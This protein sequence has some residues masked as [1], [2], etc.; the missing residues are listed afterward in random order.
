MIT[1]TL[2]TA[3]T[4]NPHKPQSQKESP[5]CSNVL[6]FC[7][8]NKLCLPT[9]PPS[10]RR[11]RPITPSS[12]TWWR[13]TTRCTA[14][15]AAWWRAW[16]SWCS[17][18]SRCCWGPSACRCWTASS[19]C[20]RCRRATP[21]ECSPVADNGWTA[22]KKMSYLMKHLPSTYTHVMDSIH[23]WPVCS[24]YAG[25]SA[26]YSKMNN[27]KFEKKLILKLI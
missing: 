8:S 6:M 24:T 10:F 26:L 16:R 27:K 2:N 3:F 5:D 7:F 19:S 18:A 1:P 15:R 17:P 20:S 9:P 11:A 12:R 21:S 14:A 4:P 23:N 25:I 22:P 13:R